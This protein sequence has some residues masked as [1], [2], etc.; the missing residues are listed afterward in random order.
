MKMSDEEKWE[1]KKC[2]KEC[3]F[4]EG[5]REPVFLTNN[6]FSVI[7][8]EEYKCETCGH[9]NDGSTIL[10]VSKGIQRRREIWNRRKESEI[11]KAREEVFE[12]G[13]DVEKKVLE[14]QE[15]DHVQQVA[16][17]TYHHTLTQVCF[18][19]GVVRTGMEKLKSG[20]EEKVNEDE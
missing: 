2:C 20:S 9:Q 14:C 4:P 8:Y 7:H 5:P 17:S 12:F 10:A 15:K 1:M 13:V 16:F 11:K 6:I 18:T 3:G 19:C